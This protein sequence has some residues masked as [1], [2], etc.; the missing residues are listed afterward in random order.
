MNSRPRPLRPT[1]SILVTTALGLGLAL[2]AACGSQSSSS[3]DP[4]SS[5]GTSSTA[6][7]GATTTG[8]DPAAEASQAV[9]V[10]LRRTGGLRPVDVRLSYSADGPLP[11]GTTQ[12]ELDDILSAASDPALR[13]VDMAPVPKNACCD[14]QSY[15]VTVSY[16]DGSTKSFATVDGVQQPQVFEKLLSMLG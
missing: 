2:T 8:N 12:A 3:G 14:L 11:A 5:V 13:T 6:P 4:A 1:R 9:A 10:S 7:G 15:Q 16:A